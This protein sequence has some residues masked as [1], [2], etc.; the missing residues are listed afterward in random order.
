MASL[1]LEVHVI[2]QLPR[3]TH[4]HHKGTTKDPEKNQSVLNKKDGR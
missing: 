1:D 2:V 3:T 4:T